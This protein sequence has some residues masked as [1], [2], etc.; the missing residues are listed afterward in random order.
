MR[1]ARR[2]ARLERLLRPVEDRPTLNAVVRDCQRLDRWLASIG[3]T[4]R[5]ALAAGLT[6]PPELGLRWTSLA[7]EVQAQDE[8]DAW[9]RE[10]Q[11]RS[12]EDRSR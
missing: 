1:Y 2:L 9:K 3:M 6:P 12:W 11:G 8:L 5:Q 7:D 10:F 4:A